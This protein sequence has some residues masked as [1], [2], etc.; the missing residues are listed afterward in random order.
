MLE[1]YNLPQKVKIG[2][3]ESEETKTGL[4]FMNGIVRNDAGE[5]IGD[6]KYI[7][8]NAPVKDE[9]ELIEWRKQTTAVDNGISADSLTGKTFSSGFELFLS[10]S[11]IIEKN[12]E[13]RPLYL[14]PMKELL[15][16]MMYL[17]TEQ[18]GM[19]FGSDINS[20]PDVHVD[21]GELSYTQSPEER[22]RTRAS[23]LL[24]GTGSVVEFVMEDNPDLSEDEAIDLIKK[25]QEWKKLTRVEN[26]FNEKTPE[27]SE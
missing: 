10:K 23:K 12:I 11:G 19:R 17:A 20:M 26:P 13:E 22:E 1:D 14:R 8:P 16:N 5:A 24:N 4:T 6:M 7:S 3:D 21:F 25:R 15:R 27:E 2:M 18:L 9:K